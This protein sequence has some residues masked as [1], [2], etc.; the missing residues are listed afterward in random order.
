MIAA[1]PR[2]LGIRKEN[3]S[4]GRSP[5]LEKRREGMLDKLTQC[6]FTTQDLSAS[7]G[8]MEPCSLLS[9]VPGT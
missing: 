5:F 7:A 9:L 8:I 3:F 1:L 2:L 6:M 4:T